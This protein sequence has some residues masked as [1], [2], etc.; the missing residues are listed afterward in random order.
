MWFHGGLPPGA[1]LRLGDRDLATTVSAAA[2]SG[3]L[4]GRA[5]LR[6]PGKL[7][8]V[9]YDP[10][11]GESVQVGEAGRALR[12][13]DGVT[14]VHDLHVWEITSHYIC[15][16]MHC[17]L[18]DLRLSEKEIQTITRWVD[19]GAPQGNPADMPPPVTFA[20]PNEWAF[21]KE[22]GPPDLIVKTKPFT[23]AAR[24]QDVWWRPIVPTGLT[25]DRCIK[26]VSV[27]PSRKGRAAA[28]GTPPSRRRGGRRQ[29]RLRGC[30]HFIGCS[31]MMAM[32]ASATSTP[33]T[34]HAV[35]RMPS[36]AHSQASATPM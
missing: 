33:V 3:R 7:A 6:S 12:A 18:D 32:P 29:R 36:T 25:K 26:A 31:M 13:L 10:A 20:N 21:E 17:V 34:S 22:M 11:S 1:R 27:K 2:V 9:L 24:G 35:G 5:L 8:L 19:S 14:D 28:P 15:L 4:R 23:L 16:S 30:I